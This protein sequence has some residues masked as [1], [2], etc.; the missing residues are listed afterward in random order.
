MLMGKGDAVVLERGSTRQEDRLYISRGLQLVAVRQGSG[1][2][3]VLSLHKR[4]PNYHVQSG[5]KQCLLSGPCEPAAVPN[6]TSSLHPASS[7]FGSS[8]CQELENNTIYF[9]PHTHS[10]HTGSPP[11]GS[12]PCFPCLRKAR[13]YPCSKGTC[14]PREAFPRR[15][16]WC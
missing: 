7:L 15:A 9:R 13:A 12:F 3:M 4:L 5:L 14:T 1:R 6:L 8:V 10:M 11:I 16:P 2:P